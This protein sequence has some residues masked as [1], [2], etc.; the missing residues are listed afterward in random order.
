MRHPNWHTRKNAL[1]RQQ[2]EKQKQR[3]KPRAEQPIKRKG[4]KSS[5]KNRKSKEVSS[6]EEDVTCLICFD[7]YLESK[8]MTGFCDMCARTGYILTVLIAHLLQVFIARIVIL[9]TETK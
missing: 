7:S 4:Q 3:R 2:I 6:S 9:I 1:E 8:E 5:K